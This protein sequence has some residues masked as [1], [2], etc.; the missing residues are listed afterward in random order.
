MSTF[1]LYHILENI[2]DNCNK[3]ICDCVI[4]NIEG[5]NTSDLDSRNTDFTNLND[6]SN[7]NF[8]IQSQ[9]NDNDAQ[10]ESSLPLSTSVNSVR[11]EN[12]NLSQHDIVNLHAN[13]NSSM[14]AQPLNLNLTTKG[15][16][17]GH[18]NIQ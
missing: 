10:A 18:L 15:L 7:L 16:K 12:D 14:T 6:N 11:T 8:S 13:D 3:T 2:C 9:T 1:N 17:I 5:P 4:D